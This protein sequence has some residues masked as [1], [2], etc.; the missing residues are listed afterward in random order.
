MS[1][2]LPGTASAQS[3]TDDCRVGIYRLHDGSDVDIGNDDGAHLRWRKE[4][5]TMG[6]LTRGPNDVWTSTLG[7]TDRSD[8]HRV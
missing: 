4:D 8:G 7:L 6:Q 5:G 3:H 2:A 1:F